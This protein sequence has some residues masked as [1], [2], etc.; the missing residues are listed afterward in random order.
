MPFQD[1]RSYLNELRE[2]SM[3]VDVNAQVDPD[4]ELTHILSEELRIGKKRTIVFNDV[5]GSSIPVAGN[6]FG[7]WERMKM[8]LGDEPINIGNRLLELVQVPSDTDS[9]MSKGLKMF[10]ELGGIRPKVHNDLD[11]DHIDAGKPDLLQYPICRTWPKDG[12]KYITLPLVI[13]KDPVSGNRNVGMYRLQL[14]DSETLGMH[15]QIHKG[16]AENYDRQRERSKPLDVAVVLGTDPLNIFSAVAPLP[17]G[18]DEFSF[19]GLIS[20]DRVDLAKGSTVNLEYPSNSEIVLEGY[21]D[22]AESRVEG[23]FG[24]HTGY[25]SLEEEFPVLHVRKVFQRKKPIY[26]TTIVGKLWHEDVI[27]GKAVERMFL[28][29]IKF[30]IPEIVD[31]NTMEEAV[32]HNMVIVSIRKRYP[33]Q[34]K[35]VMFALWGLGQLMFSKIIV[36]VDDDIDVHDR[37][38][39]IWAMST[40]IDP[41]RDV[42][43]VKGTVTDSLDHASPIFNYGSKMGIDATRKGASEGYMRRWPETMQMPPEVVESVK[44]KWGALG[45]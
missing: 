23:P 22:P 4:L 17:N 9:M 38:Q 36:V 32:F 27:L 31:L 14:Y 39:V 20:R 25:Y 44:K 40:R 37:K 42:F 16:G 10:R 13:T 28:P 26:P 7:D 43:T 21:V 2:K 29:I 15:W 1:L 8:V 33:G 34:A 41:D 45:L 11:S 6:L 24:D 35:K 30:Q 12:G 19:A 18:L 5:K 3:L